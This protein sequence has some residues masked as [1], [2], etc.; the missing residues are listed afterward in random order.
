M[1]Y[2]KLFL[3]AAGAI[4]GIHLID[5]LIVYFTTSDEAPGQAVSLIGTIPTFVMFILISVLFSAYIIAEEKH[6]E[7]GT[8]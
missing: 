2:R 3:Y 8:K 4:L 6:A 1:K 5:L 7:G